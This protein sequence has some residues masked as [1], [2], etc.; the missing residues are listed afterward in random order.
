MGR[1][2][3]IGLTS[4]IIALVAISTVVVPAHASVTLTVRQSNAIE[5]VGYERKLPVRPFHPLPPPPKK[6]HDPRCASGGPETIYGSV[7]SKGGVRLSNVTIEIE[8][9]DQH[10][11][12]PLSC[13][14]ISVGAT[15]TYRSVVHLAAGPYR[16]TVRLT[17]D[18]KKMSE[19]RSVHLQPGR[20]YQVS[21]VVRSSRIFSFL[22]V[23]SY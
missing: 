4:L 14:E 10:G 18:H 15:G 16:L 8:A 2:V 19:D 6:N 23:S 13:G 11:S 3:L 12:H 1:D 22:P 21:S 17:A 9:L 5:P 20:A 7:S